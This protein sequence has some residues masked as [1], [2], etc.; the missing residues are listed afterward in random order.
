MAPNRTATR[1]GLAG[2]ARTLAAT[3]A[4]AQADDLVA[5]GRYLAIAADCGSCHTAP[6]G[7]PFAGGRAIPTPFGTLYTPNITPDRETGIGEW[8]ENDFYRALHEGIAKDGSHIYPGMPYQWYTWATCDDV[9]AIKAY[10]VSLPPVRHPNKPNDLSFPFN[11]R[12]GLIA[13]NTA[14]FSPRHLPARHLPAR[15]LPAG[16]REIHRDRSGSLSC[17][18]SRSLRRAG[19]QHHRPGRLPEPVRRARLHRTRRPRA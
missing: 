7:H 18:G 17:R 6:G 13:W 4:P 11:V 8:S 3:M 1:S 2:L 12:A 14:F 16:P 10:V 9:A 19:T 15:H 5:R